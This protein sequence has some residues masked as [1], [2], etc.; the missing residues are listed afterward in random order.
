MY[1]LILA[2]G[3]IHLIFSSYFFLLKVFW[4]SLSD[5]PKL[6]VDGSVK[7]VI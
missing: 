2:H 1:K 7:L 3:E 4:R 5:K 6:L